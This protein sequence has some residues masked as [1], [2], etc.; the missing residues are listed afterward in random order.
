MAA[1]P[2]LVTVPL[3]GAA[4][5]GQG[6]VIAG[7]IAAGIQS[8][9]GNVAAGSVFAFFQGAGAGGAALA[10]VNGVV[11]GAGLVAAGAAAAKA[12]SSEGG[13]VSRHEDTCPRDC[14]ES[15]GELVETTKGEALS[16]C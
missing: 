16:S 13:D 14:T 7:S 10:A 11:Q 8:G 6:G 9:I 5:F 15:G 1:A 2:G 3:L 12:V 4:G